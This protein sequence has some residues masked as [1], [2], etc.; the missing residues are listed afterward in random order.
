MNDA[1]AFKGDAG[2]KQA[3][4]SDLRE[5]GPVMDAWISRSIDEAQGSAIADAQGLHTALVL[6][7]NAMAGD[8]RDTD[9]QHF[10]AGLVEAIEPGASSIDIVRRWYLWSWEQAS[11]GPQAFLRGTAAFAPAQALVEQVRDSLARH[12]D[13]R[14]WRAKRAALSQIGG[15]SPDQTDAAEIVLAMGWDLDSVPASAKDVVEAWQGA[16][17]RW[18][19]RAN[20]WTDEMEQQLIDFGMDIHDKAMARLGQPTEETKE[21]FLASY[22]ELTQKLRAESNMQPMI[23]HSNESRHFANERRW[24]W[25]D[26]ARAA[27]ISCGG[28][29]DRG[30]ILPACSPSAPMDEGACS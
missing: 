25:R 22:K 10:V 13:A 11:P 15:L 9:V 5:I 7:V 24:E 4:L 20:G 2:I 6:L 21:T 17:R 14:A 28:V 12:V 18:G 8:P 19:H 3:L 1:G 30:E 23:E 27:L 16:L 29:D 26:A